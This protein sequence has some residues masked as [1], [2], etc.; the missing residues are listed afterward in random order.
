MTEILLRFLSDESIDRHSLSQACTTSRGDGQGLTRKTWSS[1]RGL[2][3]S[4]RARHGRRW[5]PSEG[6]LVRGGV[7]PRVSCVVEYRGVVRCLL[8]P[9]ASMFFVR[10]VLP[11]NLKPTSDTIECNINIA[12]YD[13]RCT[14]S[15]S[16][17]LIYRT[18]Y[19]LRSNKKDF[20]VTSLPC[21]VGWCAQIF[22][23]SCLSRPRLMH[24]NFTL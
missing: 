8:H 13:M 23:F 6:A 7:S 24:P 21:H 4:C 2:G 5:L 20:S 12:T 19:L 17:V 1:S 15:L 11:H 16:Y 22:H 3:K 9:R 10:S 18:K 14:F